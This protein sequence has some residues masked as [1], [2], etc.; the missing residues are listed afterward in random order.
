MEEII[1]MKPNHLLANEINYELRIRGVVTGRDIS[2]KRKI[3]GRLLN[4]E[5]GRN[6]DIRD[7]EFNFET[8]REAITSSV[9][10]IKSLVRDFEGPA[11]DSLF[12]R[13]RS[14]L[15][16]V[17]SRVK[18]MEIVDDADGNHQ[19]FKNETYATCL[20]LEAEL[21]ER[22]TSDTPAIEHHA[23][24]TT[25]VQIPAQSP[26]SLQIYK[27][28]VKFD[29]IS[30][31]LGVEAFIERVEELADARGVNKSDLFASA[32]DLFTG[33]GL[34]WWRYIKPSV[35]DWDSLVRRLRSDFLSRDNDEQLW[36]IIKNRKQRNNESVTI[37]IA[38]MESY[39]RRLSN[40]PAEVTKIKKIRENLLFKYY[41]R[42]AL[43]EFESVTELA[44]TCK[45]WEEVFSTRARN[46]DM[47]YVADSST[48]SNFTQARNGSNENSFS[49]SVSHNC[50]CSCR[51][52]SAINASS[53]SQVNRRYRNSN[54]N[55]S[56]VNVISHNTNPG[57]SA[58]N[59][60][61]ASRTVCWNCNQPNHTFRSCRQ[62][63]NKFCF[64]CGKK[65]VTVSNC[66]NCS[67]NAGS[68]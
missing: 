46:S 37:F 51:C 9:E 30:Q 19:L 54:R 11:T 64:K 23:Q 50:T 7:P 25:V 39:F 57:T 62:T 24:S 47:A 20:Q 14:R 35:S 29:G 56:R 5:R 17:T 41:E 13:L 28:G 10:N 32:V 26:A 36:K 22:V 49:N 60:N 38:E 53:S 27:W 3:L 2:E 58:G 63:R 65:N 1:N 44:S 34:E 48:S 33:K 6:L 59:S 66:N 12:I 8:E 45:R 42:L 68:G 21:Y 43:T 55:S 15:I 16:H 18:R 67:G 61:N 4:R 31:R 52:S 40:V